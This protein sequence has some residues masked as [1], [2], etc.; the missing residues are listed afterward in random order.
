MNEIKKL[1]REILLEKKKKRDRC[2]RIAD[3][4]YKK[5]SAY[6]SGAA[7]R[8]RAG[9]IWKGIKEEIDPEEA[10]GDKKSIQTV[11]DGKR[12]LG[13]VVLDGL[14]SSFTERK[15]WD[16]V[17]NKNLGVIKVPSHPNRA[18]IFYRKGAE[19]EANELKAIAEKYGGYLS[20]KATDEDARKIGQLLGYK[21]EAIEDYIEK[22]KTKLNQVTEDLNKSN[23]QDSIKQLFKNIPELSA[24]GTVEQYTKYL[25]T[26]FPNSKL[27]EIV[28]HGGT[29]D[30]KD[31]G[32]DSFTGEIGG[33]HGLYFTGSSGRAKSYIKAGSKDY[34]SKSKIYS[35]LLNIQ[36]PLD[37][38]IWSK[39]KFGADTI[40]DEGL[41]QMK[42]TNSDGI[43]VTDVFSKYTNIQY[44]TQ[45]VV[46]SMD[47]V[48]IL[49]SSE[50][51]EGFKKYVSKTITEELIREK[52]KETLRTWFKRKGAPG[53]TGGWVD[54]NSPIRK[55]GKITGYKAC[56]RQKGEK[57]AK[58]PSCRPTP[59]KCK[60]PGKG[61]KWG[62][63]K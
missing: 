61:T 39:W 5:P 42:E 31:R 33:K 45:Y 50:D 7:E 48:H 44:N 4:K 25:E 11:I 34:M 27:E 59:A 58:Y 63:T 17:Q 1:I 12:K 29:L 51:I 36:N 19:N 57:R 46:L 47:Q 35:A 2:L 30:P 53:K 32:K 52:T 60:S 9:K 16:T 23:N 14:D 10:Y 3:R 8:C 38:K 28:Y 15:F 40:T 13:F 41:K 43:I 54:C 20:Y 26:I 37:K 21:A 62:K 22:R 6:K 49:G 55:K 24:I 18:Y 56:G